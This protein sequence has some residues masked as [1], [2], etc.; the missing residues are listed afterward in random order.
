MI[1]KICMMIFIYIF[2]VP[3][4][5]LAQSYKFQASQSYE[6]AYFI[7]G[8]AKQQ[9]KFN[10][11]TLI[12]KSCIREE[13]SD[14]YYTEPDHSPMNKYF[15][16]DWN[17]FTGQGGILFYGKGTH[18]TSQFWEDGY[19]RN[20]VLN[21]GLHANLFFN[22]GTYWGVSMVGI[23]MH[24]SPV[25]IAQI[26]AKGNTNYSINLEVRPYFQS[27]NYGIDLLENKGAI[28]SGKALWKLKSPTSNYPLYLLIITSC[29]VSGRVGDTSL[30]VF[31]DYK[32]A[33]NYYNNTETF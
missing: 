30:N 5:V 17:Q 23:E 3:I 6:L 11:S 21:Y 15:P 29:G 24:T 12:E 27:Y 2:L 33:Q 18:E 8:L 25:Y 7:N 4:S 19:L 14:V 22:C 28:N 16:N 9:Q 26:I 32:I 1:R 10:G 31:Y 13:F 20:R